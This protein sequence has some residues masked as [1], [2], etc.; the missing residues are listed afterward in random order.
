VEVPSIRFGR[1]IVA[2]LGRK[3]LV[4]SEKTVEVST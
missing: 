3:R 2:S 4:K 1:T